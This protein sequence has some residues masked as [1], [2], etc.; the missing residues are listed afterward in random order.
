MVWRDKSKTRMVRLRQL[1]SATLRL[2]SY[3]MSVIREG[4]TVERRRLPPIPSSLVEGW[5]VGFRHVRE[6]SQIYRT[7]V[8]MHARY[9]STRL[10]AAVISA[11]ACRATRLD[12]A[13]SPLT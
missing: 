7:A 4:D 3:A 5:S 13:S 2:W 12:I 11:D 8:S 6:T 10:A 1:T 9:T